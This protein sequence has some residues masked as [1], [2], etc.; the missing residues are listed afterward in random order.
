[1]MA[2][3]MFRAMLMM[4]IVNYLLDVYDGI[5]SVCAMLMM[6]IVNY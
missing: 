1:M 5:R 3:D 4:L 6:L 2:L